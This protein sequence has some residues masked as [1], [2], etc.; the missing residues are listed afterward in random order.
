MVQLE[1][2]ETTLAYALGLDIPRRDETPSFTKWFET[3]Y[4]YMYIMYIYL[5]IYLEVSSTQTSG[6]RKDVCVYY[7]YIYLY[8]NL[9]KNLQLEKLPSNP[10]FTLF[11]SQQLEF[12]SCG[13]HPL[14]VPPPWEFHSLRVPL[15]ESSTPLGVPLGVPL[16]WE[17]HS[18][19][20]STSWEFQPL[21]VPP[22]EISTFW[23]VW[24]SHV[25]PPVKVP[26]N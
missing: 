3:K 10:N 11:G 17:F 15:T 5:I 7:I 4:I 20:S 6:N 2:M 14:R 24:V 18:S 25:N 26:Q 13:F 8:K 12:H 21:G 22:P 19:G 9:R 23:K 1:Q 16:P